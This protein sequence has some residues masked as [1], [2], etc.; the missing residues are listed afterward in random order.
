MAAKPD[1]SRSPPE[2]VARFDEIAAGYPD[3]P[4]RLSFGYPCLFVG[5]NMV[6]GLHAARWFVRLGERALAEALALEGAG[7]LEV[8]P[9]RSMTG[10]AVLPQ[11]VVDDEAAIRAW[12]DRAI[13]FGATLPA[14]ASKAK[15]AQKAPKKRA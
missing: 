15:A 3:V 13:E 2:L 6:T 14:K 11:A 5:G 7:P 12:V 1:F 4:R 10:Y 8:M 9:G